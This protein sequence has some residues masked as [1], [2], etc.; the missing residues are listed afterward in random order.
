MIS[1]YQYIWTEHVILD[2]TVPERCGCIEVQQNTA[3][4][5]D[6]VMCDRWH[7]TENWVCPGQRKGDIDESTVSRICL[8]GR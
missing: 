4:V 2:S 7:K 6:T 3:K 5:R 8:M 1:T